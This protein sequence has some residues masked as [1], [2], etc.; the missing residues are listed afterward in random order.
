[1]TINKS[2]QGQVIDTFD[3]LD[4]TAPNHANQWIFEANYK[5]AIAP[6]ISLVPTAEYVVH[7]DEIGFDSPAPGVDHALVVGVQVAI[8]FG[9]MLGL[10][11]WVRAD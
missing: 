6:G 10:P 5:V 9:E 11:H 2:V 4:L 8:N 7:P 3:S 1:L